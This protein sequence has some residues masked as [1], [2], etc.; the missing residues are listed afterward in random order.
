MAYEEFGLLL[1]FGE[2]KLHVKRKIRV[3]NAA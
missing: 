1:N 2:R 3:L